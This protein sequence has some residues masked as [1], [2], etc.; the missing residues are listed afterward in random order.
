MYFICLLNS[1]ALESSSG[2]AGFMGNPVQH[3][4][5]ASLKEADNISA[6]SHRANFAFLSVNWW[7]RVLFHV[8]RRE[9]PDVRRARNQSEGLPVRDA[10]EEASSL[11][12]LHQEAV[13]IDPKQKGMEPLRCT[14]IYSVVKVIAE[15]R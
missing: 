15:F 3:Q 6:A 2:N 4:L 9:T 11:W 1:P 10:S 14:L 7:Q 5:C 13:H 12:R 8:K